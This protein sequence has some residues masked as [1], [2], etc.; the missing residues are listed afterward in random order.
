MKIS[1]SSNLKFFSKEVFFGPDSE[2]E[3]KKI[4]NTYFPPK[5][6]KIFL[7]SGCKIKF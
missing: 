7:K 2:S 3:V 1:K 6:F 5:R 4:S